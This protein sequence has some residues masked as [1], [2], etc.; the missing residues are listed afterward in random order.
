MNPYESEVIMSSRFDEQNWHLDGITIMIA[1][2]LKKEEFREADVVFQLNEIGPGTNEWCFAYYSYPDSESQYGDFETQYKESE[3]ED[4]DKSNY[5]NQFGIE[6]V[7][8]I[9]ENGLGDFELKYNI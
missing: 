7:K 5:F 2:Y 6:A 1:C 3:F 4:L 8:F 9:K